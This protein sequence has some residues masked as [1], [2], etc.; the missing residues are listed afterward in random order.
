MDLRIGADPYPR[1]H[2][3]L[4]LRRGPCIGPMC[5]PLRFA[6]PSS[7]AVWPD[8][9]LITNPKLASSA[10][11][12]SCQLQALKQVLAS[13]L[14]ALARQLLSPEEATN[15]IGDYYYDDD[16]TRQSSV[17]VMRASL[18]AANGATYATVALVG[19]TGGLVGSGVRASCE[20]QTKA[21]FAL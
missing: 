21:L 14:L 3:P 19:W 10:R 12:W 6:S 7:L 17:G 1:L 5:P 13:L 18:F 16:S 20:V 9:H 15:S 11:Q 2:V 4:A 8:R